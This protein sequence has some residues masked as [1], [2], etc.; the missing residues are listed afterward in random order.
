MHGDLMDGNVAD[1]L[2]ACIEAHGTDAVNIDDV[3]RR[4]GRSRS[5]LYRQFGTWT[6][7]VTCVHWQV[8]ELFD[9]RFPRPGENRRLEF[10]QWWSELI[11]FL[12][13]P[14][15]R[16]ALGLR[17]LASNRVGIGRLEEEELLRLP[18]LAKWLKASPVVVKTTWR[19]LLSAADPAFDDAQRAELREIV[20][21][22]V[23]AER[24]VAPA[25]DD[26]DLSEA[27][28]LG[29]LL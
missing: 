5:A 3:A 7:L 21:A 6:Q 1:A 22:V 20:W 25:T 18:A 12:L 17:Q 9:D 19:L 27:V 4:L 23:G 13:T 28:A 15:G 24:T 16:G 10:E 11:G 26:F 2:F 29:E 8:I 14:Y